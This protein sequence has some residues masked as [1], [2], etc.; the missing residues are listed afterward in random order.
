MNQELFDKFKD[1]CPWRRTYNAF[2]FIQEC[3]CSM[4][5][6]APF[7]WATKTAEDVFDILND[8]M[9]KYPME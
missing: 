7:Y 1:G 2:C 9:D 5:V 6:C 8:I 3:D 4:K